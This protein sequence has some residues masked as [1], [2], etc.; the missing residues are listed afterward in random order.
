MNDLHS[1][2]Q[3]TYGWTVN[4]YNLEFSAIHLKHLQNVIKLCI[5]VYI[6]RYVLN[7]NLFFMKD[8]IL[9]QLLDITEDIILQ[10]VTIY[11]RGY[12]SPDGYYISKK[13]LFFI[14]LTT[15]YYKGHYSSDS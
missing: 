1:G 13:I 11:Q 5:L 14:Q 7:V 6:L 15:T 2:E 9:Q 10:T 3:K 4:F 8:I 12:Y